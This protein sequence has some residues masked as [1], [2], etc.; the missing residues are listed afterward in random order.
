MRKTLINLFFIIF[1]TSSVLSLE[2]KTED[3]LGED[4]IYIKRYQDS[5]I[6]AFS[7]NKTGD[8]I[9]AT[10]V[11]NR[12]DIPSSILKL[13]GKRKR[14]TYR[15]KVYLLPSKIF[16]HYME[17]FIKEDWKI[18]FSEIGRKLDNPETRWYDVVYPELSL[19]KEFNRGQRSKQYYAVV[20]K[21]LYNERVYIV[22][23][24]TVDVFEIPVY[25]IDIITIPLKKRF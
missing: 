9:I 7:E 25:Q 16:F 22:L 21:I 10:G 12:D 5:F 14:Y 20:S 6:T 1:F 11:L 2:L 18:L 23:Y 19:F 8:Y 17:K 24:V 13:S 4:S 3:F 15:S